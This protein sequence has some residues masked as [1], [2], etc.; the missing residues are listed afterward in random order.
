[1]YWLARSIRHFLGQTMVPR[2]LHSNTLGMQ[3]YL[4]SSG[5][6]NITVLVMKHEK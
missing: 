5:L 2:C 4:C 3:A 1:M 6:P